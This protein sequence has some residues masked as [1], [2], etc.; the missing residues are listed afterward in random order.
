MLN[1]KNTY[2]IN[3][4]ISPKRIDFSN[5]MLLVSPVH[6][7]QRNINFEMMA[8][9]PATTTKL[10]VEMVEELKQNLMKDFKKTS[11]KFN[12]Y[13]RKSMELITYE[14]KINKLY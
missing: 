6:I 7:K 12:P 1:R 13:R 9:K 11:H 2:N 5:V 3:S 8:N 4:D 10:S 14:E